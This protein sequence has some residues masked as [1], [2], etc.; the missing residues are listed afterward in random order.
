M[1]HD[2]G[3]FLLIKYGDL[4]LAASGWPAQVATIVAAALATFLVWRAFRSR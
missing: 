3:D 4:W 1:T 2:P